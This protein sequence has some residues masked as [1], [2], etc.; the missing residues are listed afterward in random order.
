[1]FSDA[2]FC[3]TIQE[4]GTR[5]IPLGGRDGESGQPVRLHVP[6]LFAA[7]PPLQKTYCGDICG[8]VFERIQVQTSGGDCA[9]YC[10]LCMSGSQVAYRA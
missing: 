10:G 6:A 2:H 7:K 8:L 1:M 3:R 5:P 9:L 4:G